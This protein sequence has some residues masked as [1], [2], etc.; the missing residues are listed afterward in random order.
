[1]AT[2][3]SARAQRG[4]VVDPVA[5]HGHDVAAGLERLD[6]PR[7]CA[8]ATPGRTRR[9][10]RSAAASSLVGHAVEVAPGD[11]L[12]ARSRARRRSRAAVVAWSPVIIFTAMPAPWHTAM[13]SR[14]SARGGSTM[15]TRPTKV[16]LG[17]PL[18][19]GASG[20]PKSS[21]SFVAT[22]STRRPRPASARCVVG[23][24]GACRVVEQRHRP[25]R[26]L[27]RRAAAEQDVGGP[28]RCT[29]HSL[30]SSAR[31]SV[32][33]NLRAESN[34]TSPTR[35]VPRPQR[36][37]ASTP[38]LA[39]STTRAPSVGSPTMPAVV[40]AGTASVHSAGAGTATPG[41]RVGAAG[42]R[43][44]RRRRWR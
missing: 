39:A 37:E 19:Q 20:S 11:D 41:G 25:V 33:M 9:C 3:M 38:A 31:G 26:A 35:R 5:G 23:E 27:D 42:R 1:M 24:R 17:Q 29:R 4:G 36:L 13:A 16:S 21:T 22:A 34:G 14:A 6:D 32:A 2:P 18:G 10:R 7:P 15:P 8:R 30:S 12:A 44:D 28:L 40:G 43:R